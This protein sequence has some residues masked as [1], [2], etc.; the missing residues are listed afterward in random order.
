MVRAVQCGVH[1]R[2][3]WD[4]TWKEVMV[5]IKG[6]EKRM[7]DKLKSTRLICYM[8]YCANTQNPVSLNSFMPIPDDYVY[9]DIEDDDD[10]MSAEMVKMLIDNQRKRYNQ[11]G[12]A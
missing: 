10:E 4:L 1:V 5:V 9:E 8:T 11:M 6:Y 3:F 12:Y 2:E 7:T